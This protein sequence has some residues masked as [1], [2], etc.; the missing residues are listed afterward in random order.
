MRWQAFFLAVLTGWGVLPS[1]TYAQEPIPVQAS[2]TA[3]VEDLA[4]VQDPLIPGAFQ[5]AMVMDVAT[6]RILYAYQPDRLHP[7]ASLTKLA[8]AL[9]FVKRPINWNRIVVLKKEDEVGGGRL[10][11]KPGSRL[12]VRDFFYA[13]ITSSANNAANALM[14]VSGLKRASFL[15]QMNVEA[16]RAGAQR[17]VFVDAT[18]MSPKNVT[19]ARDM[20]MIARTAF[21]QPLI[22]QAAGTATYRM[23]VRNT[24][25]KKTITNTNRLLT[26]DESV[27]IVSGKTGYLHEAGNNLAVEI[28]PID[29]TGRPVT[30]SKRLVVVLGSPTKA[31]MFASAK[32]LAAWT[33][34]HH[35]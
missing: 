22:R 7:A 6:R 16:R 20:A 29:T 10:R 12:S 2:T 33:W 28:M 4:S 32:R 9:V 25:E 34:T 21:R 14:R 19:T 15:K 11:L 1:F 3:A 31:G 18:G 35:P 30:K 27:W 26:G 23:T 24:G 17:S 8:N 13:S 5:S